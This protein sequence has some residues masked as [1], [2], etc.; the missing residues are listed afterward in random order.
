MQDQIKQQIERLRSQG[1]IYVDARWI[2]FEE[3]NQ[4]LM[5]NGNL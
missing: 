4:L 1:A 3:S 5:W 2:P